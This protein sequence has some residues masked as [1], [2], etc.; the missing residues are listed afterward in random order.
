MK[1]VDDILAHYGVKGMRWGVRKSSTTPIAVVVGTKGKK[2]VTS[3]GKN[4]PATDDAK[5]AA[6]ARQLV[7]GSSTN[8]L[9][10]KELQTAV[11]RMNLEQQYSRLAVQHGSRL[12]RGQRQ[13]K[14]LL[15][16]GKT[17]QEAHNLASGSLAKEL[18]DL[19]KKQPK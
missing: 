12:S 17:A 6:A 4:Q 7:K 15:G 13:V 19:L 1:E 11:T 18:G 8:A 2:I 10:N 3:G 16:L 5:T 9:T 14:T